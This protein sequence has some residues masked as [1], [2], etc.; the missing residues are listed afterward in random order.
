MDFNA[1]VRK[2]GAVREYTSKAID[3]TEVEALLNAAV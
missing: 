3:R 1:V 2:R